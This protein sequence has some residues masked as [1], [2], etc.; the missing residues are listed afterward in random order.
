MRFDSFINEGF[1]I[2]D[3]TVYFDP[4]VDGYIKTTFGKDKKLTPYKMKIPFGNLYA[5]YLRSSGSSEDYNEVIKTIKG[6]NSKYTMDSESYNKFLKRTALYM[7]RIILENE[8]DTIILMDSTSKILVEFSIHLNKY[9][10]KYY[11]MLTYDKGIFKNPN[12]EEIIINTEKYNLKSETIDSL[13]KTINRQLK[14]N[15][16]SIKKFPPQFRKVI[17]NWLKI[18]DKLL[19]KIVEKRICIIDDIVTTGSTI[20]EASKMLEEAG[21]EDLLCLALI[22]GKHK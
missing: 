20:K 10:P 17:S 8:I 9:L 15:Y 16:F 4:N 7:S 18:E 13:Q 19:S 2:K 3:N 6:Q 5:V 14:S 1:V 22:K 12:L 21:A 11:E